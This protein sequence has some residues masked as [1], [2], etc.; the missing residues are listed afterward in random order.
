MVSTILYTLAASFVSADYV[1][2]Y[3][4]TLHLS[5]AEIGLYG[6]LSHMATLTAYA[7]F[8]LFLPGRKNYIPLLFASAFVMALFP[9]F[10]LFAG[11]ASST[12]GSMLLL[13]AGCII[14]QF[15]VGVK[16]SCEYAE[17]PSLFPRSVYGN[18]LGKCG[19]AGS[20]VAAV[21]SLL[22]ALLL[23]DASEQKSYSVLFLSAFVLLLFSA[24]SVKRYAA[25]P[26]PKAAQTTVSA[27]RFTRRQLWLLLP[28]LLR[29]VAAGSAYYWVVLSLRPIAMPASLHSFLITFGVS[30]AM[31]GCYLF[32]RLEKRLRS[33]L[34]VFIAMLG[35][36]ASMVLAL[37]VSSVPLFFLAYLA[38]V[39]LRTIADY[40]I[41][42]GMIY[43]VPQENLAFHA[44][45]RMLLMSGASC[46][47]IPAFAALMD[48]WPAGSVLI[49]GAAAYLFAGLFFFVQYTDTTR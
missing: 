12:A 43:N 25:I 45:M 19:M 20:A 33:G 6:S 23:Q 32:V 10:L 18:L 46:L 24:L 14:Y 34:L 47:S 31:L 9:L 38:H 49:I 7:F 44:S 29:G 42:A 27:G 37:F 13:S 48:V 26:P 41:P 35:T 40:S 5:T 1:Q 15:S 8:G 30:G 22:N 28:H 11:M 39:L 21:M 16:S 4:L 2:A 36:A 17:I 3:L